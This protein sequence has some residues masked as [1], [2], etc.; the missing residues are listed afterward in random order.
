MHDR[1]SNT[2]P[3]QSRFQPVTAIFGLVSCSLLVIF[4]GW[5][6]FIAK[7][8]K[9]VDVIAAYLGPIVFIA[10]YI[11]HKLKYGT[12]M[13]PLRSL[14]YTSLR[15][16]NDREPDPSKHGRLRKLFEMRRPTPR[17]SRDPMHDG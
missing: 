13:V 9:P 12:Q 3:F 10:I 15:P 7:P 4:N 5:D 17:L 16:D 2:Y 1:T 14:D 6:T 11:F 8:I